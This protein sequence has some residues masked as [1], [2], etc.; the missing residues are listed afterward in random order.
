MKLTTGTG[1]SSIRPPRIGEAISVFPLD[2]AS[3]IGDSW[4]ASRR[5]ERRV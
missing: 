4:I 2:D 1:V 5:V 3:A